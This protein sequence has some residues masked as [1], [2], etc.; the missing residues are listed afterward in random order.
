MLATAADREPGY[1]VYKASS[2]TTSARNVEKLKE[3]KALHPN[4]ALITIS[5]STKDGKMRG[6]CEI[7]HDCDV[8]VKVESGVTTTTKNR[9]KEKGMTLNPS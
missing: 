5:Q 6:P 1:E 9:F 7:V 4:S 3:L 8:A 2:Y